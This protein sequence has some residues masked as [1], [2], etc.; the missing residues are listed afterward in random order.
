MRRNPGLARRFRTAI[1]QSLAY[2]QAHPDEVRALLPAAQRTVRLPIWTPLVDRQKVAQLARYTKQYG[3]IRAA[4][5]P[6][7]A[8]PEP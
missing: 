8:D 3:V 5:E 6:G 7:G 1:N 2:A 4:A